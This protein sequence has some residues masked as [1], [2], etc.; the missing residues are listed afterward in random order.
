[1]GAAH[2]SHAYYADLDPY[3]GRLDAAAAIFEVSLAWPVSRVV[4]VLGTGAFAYAPTPSSSYGADWEAYGPGWVVT[5]TVGPLTQTY[6]GAGVALRFWPSELE[7]QFTLGWAKL[8]SAPRD[9]PAY[10][11]DTHGLAYAA[12]LCYSWRIGPL[13]IGPYGQWLAASSAA[14]PDLSPEYT[15]TLAGGLQLA[16]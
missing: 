16:Y 6:L 11:V 1:V 5:D 8:T 7:A 9:D 12:S 3:N 2:L 10:E 4:S 15:T 13:R 14:G